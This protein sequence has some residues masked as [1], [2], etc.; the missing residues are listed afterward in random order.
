MI[1]KGLRRQWKQ[2][3]SIHEIHVILDESDTAIP[4][5]PL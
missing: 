5:E 2:T 1:P 3:E 4:D